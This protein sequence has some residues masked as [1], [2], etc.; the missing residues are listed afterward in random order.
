MSK[1]ITRKDLAII[2]ECSV[3][4]VRQNEVRWGIKAVRY[5]LNVRCV[6]YLRDACLQILKNRKLTV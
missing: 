2:L 4:Q 5:D 6:R 1:Y 3:F